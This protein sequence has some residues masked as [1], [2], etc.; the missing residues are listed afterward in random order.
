[1]HE[2]KSQLLG[3]WALAWRNFLL[4]NLLCKTL[5]MIFVLI[6]KDSFIAGSLYQ[7]VETVL[8]NDIKKQSMQQQRKKNWKGITVAVGSRINNL[9]LLFIGKFTNA[10]TLEKYTLYFFFQFFSQMDSKL[11]IEFSPLICTVG[12]ETLVNKLT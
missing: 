10:K 3:Y 11:V 7:I 6:D 12:I 9:K 5:Q 1:M 8:K 2:G 4:I